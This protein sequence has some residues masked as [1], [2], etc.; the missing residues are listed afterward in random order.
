MLGGEAMTTAILA[1]LL[2]FFVPD[3]PQDYS[4]VLMPGGWMPPSKPYGMLNTSTDWVYWY[5]QS[6]NGMIT[7][8]PVGG[9]MAPGQST[10]LILAPAVRM[11]DAE[12]GTHVDSVNVQFDKRLVGDLDGDGSVDVCDL[13][14]FGE[15][16]RSTPVDPVA[17]FDSN[18]IID[19]VDMLYLAGSWGMTFYGIETR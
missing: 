15:C 6:Q 9:W 3:P 13:I 5:P 10:V 16:W 19:V 14:A 18:G 17:D 11:L 1:I 4:P 2:A 8:V 12:A 7:T